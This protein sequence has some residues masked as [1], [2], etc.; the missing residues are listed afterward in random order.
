LYLRGEGWP[1]VVCTLVAHHSGSRFGARVLGLDARLRQFAFVEDP[2]SDALPVA[3]NTA[4]PNGTMMT[5]DERLREK[6][7]R[8][9]RNSL[10]ARANPGATTT[11]APPTG[12]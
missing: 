3:D 9:G 7:T 11:S 12:E 10:N 4:G 2:Q 1:Q 8:H 5:V 6:L